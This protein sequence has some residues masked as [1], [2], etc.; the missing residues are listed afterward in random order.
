[1][2]LEPS[3]S[4]TPLRIGH[5]VYSIA[6][7][8]QQKAADFFSKRLQFRITDH[9]ADTGDFMRCNGSVDHHNLFFLTIPNRPFFDHVAFEVKDF[10]EIIFGGKSMRAKGWKADAAPGRHVLGSNL[11]WYFN[12]PAGGNVE[13]FA[14][15]DEMDDDFQ[16]RNWE[17]SPGYARWII[18]AEDVVR[19]HRR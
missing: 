12:N 5:V 13:Y 1:M 2:P 11:F 6:R 4:V 18:E 10:D 3:P 17:K 19:S 7:N 14:D 16:T 9:T 8:D 15:M